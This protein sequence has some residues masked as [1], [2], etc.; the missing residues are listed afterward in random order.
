MIDSCGCAMSAVF[1][2]FE[3]LGSTIW[4][5][6]VWRTHPHS[7]WSIAWRL[8]VVT[9]ALAAIGKMLGMV[10]YRMRKR[11]GPAPRARTVKDKTADA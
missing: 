8:T 3:I 1:M 5:P 2:S 4:M 11:L 6:V 9:F 10:A 7:L